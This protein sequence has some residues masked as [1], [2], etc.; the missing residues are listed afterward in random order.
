MCPKIKC[1]LLLLLAGCNQEGGIDAN[2]RELLQCARIGMEA[3]RNGTVVQP[4]SQPQD[5]NVRARFGNGSVTSGTVETAN[6]AT[7]VSESTGDVDLEIAEA[8]APGLHPQS[9]GRYKEPFF[10][11][12]I[13]TGRNSYMGGC[14]NTNVDY[15]HATRLMFGK[16]AVI[17]THVAYYHH[18]STHEQCW[19]IYVSGEDYQRPEDVRPSVCFCGDQNNPNPPSEQELRS[20]CEAQDRM[21]YDRPAQELADYGLPNQAF[22]FVLYTYTSITEAVLNGVARS[23]APVMIVPACV[24]RFSPDMPQGPRT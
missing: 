18:R 19:A 24:L 21:L 20:Y 4:G 2:T 8:E 23:M 9:Q 10:S 7:L 12:Q 17:D 13:S 3:C 11:I 1:G 5:Q 15:Y 14:V 22:R 6:T 16:K